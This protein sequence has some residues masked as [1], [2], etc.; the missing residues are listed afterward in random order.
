MFM[1]LVVVVIIVVLG[2]INILYPNYK[3]IQVLYVLIYFEDTD[4]VLLLAI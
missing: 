3:I 1:V 2:Y 4:S